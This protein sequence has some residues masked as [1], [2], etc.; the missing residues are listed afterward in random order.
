MPLASS[1]GE[2]ELGSRL[3]P[4]VWGKGT[5]LEG[6]EAL[7]R[8][9]FATLRLPRVWGTCAPGNRGARLCLGALGFG[10]LGLA[11]YEGRE[12]LL[13]MLSACEATR[14]LARPRR[15]RLRDAALCLGEA[16]GA[17]AR[18]KAIAD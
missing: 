18:A 4:E 9:A 2:A 1:P 13:H 12:A 3:V 6:G 5:A 8:H 15:E 14:W 7:L 16:D 17:A 11:P 10:E